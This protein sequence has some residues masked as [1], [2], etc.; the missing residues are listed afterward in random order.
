MKNYLSEFSYKSKRI[1]FGDEILDKLRNAA[2]KNTG[3]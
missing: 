1:F 2:L 3:N